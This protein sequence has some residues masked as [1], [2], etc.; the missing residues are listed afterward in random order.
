LISTVCLARLDGFKQAIHESIYFSKL[1][2]VYYGDLTLSHI[3]HYRQN[4]REKRKG[5]APGA[6]FLQMKLPFE[7]VPLYNIRQAQQSYL[8][9]ELVTL[10]LEDLEQGTYNLE[11]DIYQTEAIQKMILILL[12]ELNRAAVIA[13]EDIVSNFHRVLKHFSHFQLEEEK[14]K[15][16]SIFLDKFTDQLKDNS[17]AHP[18]LPEL[19]ALTPASLVVHPHWQLAFQSNLYE[20]LAEALT[21]APKSSGSLGLNLKSLNLKDQ[22][23]NDFLTTMRLMR[24]LHGF[25]LGSSDQ[26][27]KSTFD[28][29]DTTQD[30]PAGPSRLLQPDP[31]PSNLY[32]MDAI[33]DAACP[34]DEK[35]LRETV[36]GTH[37]ELSDEALRHLST[38]LDPVRTML[39]AEIRKQNDEFF[40]E[41]TQS[42]KTEKN[43]LKNQRK[44][45]R[46]KQKAKQEKEK[47]NSLL[48]ELKSESPES[49]ENPNTQNMP[50]VVENEWISPQATHAY[51]QTLK[52]ENSK[53]L[54]TQPMQLRAEPWILLDERPWCVYAT[55]LNI[56]SAVETF[57]KDITNS[58]VEKLIT[59]L[60]GQRLQ[61]AGNSRLV[62]PSR[63]TGKPIPITMHPRHNGAD[64]Y[65]I[66][67]LQA[68][69]G[70]SLTRAG[71]ATDVTSLYDLRNANSPRSSHSH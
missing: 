26:L 65:P 68:F 37:K 64:V 62:V 56:R 54:D 30:S 35:L 3:N 42:I 29:K 21:P 25:Y 69:L 12:N 11:D 47:A 6:P 52:A 60:G 58:D 66:D 18:K 38:D 17:E 33:I 27:L 45:Q 53:T 32:W 40:L 70:L 43:R 14:M 2:Q 67:T 49:P 48:Q 19:Q 23:L 4:W 39:S 10:Y 20:A 1:Q 41:L 51:F 8:F 63:S 34:R 22:Y 5:L 71:Y 55:A 24:H 50:N 7:G 15:S 44:K 46:A 36:W 59:Q 31:D 28:F 9:W 13:F 61:I 57:C 16:V